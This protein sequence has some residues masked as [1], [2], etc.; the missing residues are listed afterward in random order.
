MDNFCANLPAL[1]SAQM[2]IL[3]DW[4]EYEQNFQGQAWIDWTRDHAEIPIFSV[5]V[6]LA[7]V[8]YGPGL[9]DG[10]KFNLRTPVAVSRRS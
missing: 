2:S 4:N 1:L 10:R 8:F 7:I 6:Y 5:S 3:A 9:L